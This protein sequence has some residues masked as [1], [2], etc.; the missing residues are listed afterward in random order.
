MPKVAHIALIEARWTADSLRAFGAAVSVR[1]L[2]NDVGRLHLGLL[3]RKMFDYLHDVVQLDVGVVLSHAIEHRLWRPFGLGAEVFGSI[4]ERHAGHPDNPYN[5]GLIGVVET[6]VP[7]QTQT[8]IGLAP[9]NC[10]SLGTRHYGREKSSDHVQLLLHN[11]P[12]RITAGVLVQLFREVRVAK[13]GAHI[14]AWLIIGVDR[15]KRLHAAC[16]IDEREAELARLEV[17]SN[18]RQVSD[19]LAWAAPF[20]CRSWAIES[21]GGLG[22]LLAQQLVARGEHVV[23]VPARLS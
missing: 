23:D 1:W 3:R 19:L 4:G 11:H 16:A 15:H 20:E 12:H 13:A 8:D 9:S 6:D 21:A 7:H 5:R 14:T 22:Y 17:R 10:R 2:V 18:S